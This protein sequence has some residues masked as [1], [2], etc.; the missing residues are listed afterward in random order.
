MRRTLTLFFLVLVLTL[1][2]FGVVSALLIGQEDQVRFSETVTYGDPA[3]AT[4]LGNR[5]RSG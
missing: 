1:G 2:S 3:V 5:L 4:F